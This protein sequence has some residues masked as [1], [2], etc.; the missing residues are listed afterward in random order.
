MTWLGLWRSKAGRQ[1]LSSLW[2]DPLHRYL[3]LSTV[4]PLV[5]FSVAKSK[6]PLYIL[7]VAPY[8]VMLT[9]SQARSRAHI[10][11]GARVLIATMVLAVVKGV[12]A[13]VPNKRDTRALAQSLH[14]TG[15][16]ANECIDVLG[17]KVHGLSL[18]GYPRSTW[19]TLWPE[20]Y[21][22]FE[23]PRALAD[24]LR[25]L[26]HRCEG[27]AR[28]LVDIKHKQVAVS[29]FASAQLACRDEPISSELTL[30]SCAGSADSGAVE[31]RERRGP[32]WGNR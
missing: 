1:Q 19:H 23:A 5:V 9:I 25:G 32:P 10:R 29:F 17:T 31:A 14:R 16:T 30:F 22:Y 11:W 3:V 24:D 8:L 12:I 4:L 7:P 27:R 26:L 18:Y 13:Y 15:V 20:P 21:P 6:L 2:R 28:F